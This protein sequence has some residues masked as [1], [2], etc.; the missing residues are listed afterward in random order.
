M[1]SQ[2][3][4]FQE[5]VCFS[6]YSAAN[7]MVREYREDL[8]E[9]ELTYPQFLVMMALW[10]Q[11]AVNIKMLSEQIYLDAATLTQILKRLESKGYI[12]RKVSQEDERAKIIE[13]TKLG[14]SLENKTA[15]IFKNMANTIKLSKGEQKEVTNICHKIM[16]RITES[17][18]E[19]P[20]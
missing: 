19:V 12:Q 3:Y 6:L 4:C 9:F 13:L 14:K 16:T 18:C 10:N 7:A 20:V 2:K 17:Y 1:A 8:D 5:F 15:H 11:N